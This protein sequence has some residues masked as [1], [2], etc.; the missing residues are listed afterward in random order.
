[1][2]FKTILVSLF[3]GAVG[4]ANA[5]LMPPKEAHEEVDKICKDGCVVLSGPEIALFQANVQAFVEKQ[6]QAAFQAGQQD[7]F[8]KGIEAA[9]NN[10]KVCPKNI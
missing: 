9:R 6:A 3:M 4:C 2:L 7:G 10:P 5:Q 8:A 1:M